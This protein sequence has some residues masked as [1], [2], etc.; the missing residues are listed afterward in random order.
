MVHASSAAAALTAATAQRWPTVEL[1]AGGRVVIELA[2]EAG[3][4]T[5]DEYNRIIYKYF[6]DS[7]ASYYC[8][9]KRQ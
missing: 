4:L 3:E 8:G 6:C 7:G 9:K 1:D 5:G 2:A